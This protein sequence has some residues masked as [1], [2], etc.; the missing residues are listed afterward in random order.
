MSILVCSANEALGALNKSTFLA[1]SICMQKSCQDFSWWIAAFF[2]PF[3][4]APT[5]VFLTKIS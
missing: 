3:S 2:L 5:Y 1:S 4:S